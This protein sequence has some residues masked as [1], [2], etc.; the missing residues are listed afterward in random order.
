MIA[1]IPY[2]C[3]FL[4]V[5]ATT[6]L[7]SPVPSESHSPFGLPPIDPRG[8]L[9]NIPIINTLLCPRQGTSGITIT[10]PLGKAQG[11]VDPSGAYRFP[12]K[13]G[14]AQRWA[15]SSM[16]TTWQLP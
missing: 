16:A 11:V 8:I 10:T 15:A 2:I 3:S 1:F 7:A 6:T 12:V 4:L 14:S 9:C 13:Y 5:A